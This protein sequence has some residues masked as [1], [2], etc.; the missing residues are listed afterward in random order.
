VE[1]LDRINNHQVRFFGSDGG[2][3]FFGV[4]CMGKANEM[5]TKPEPIKPRF[6]LPGG[7]FARNIE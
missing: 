3:D 6:Y 4:G 7:F 1:R 5:G 2:N